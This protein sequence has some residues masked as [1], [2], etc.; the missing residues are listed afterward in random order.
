MKIYLFVGV[1]DISLNIA[2]FSDKQ[3]AILLECV[4][5]LL[6]NWRLMNDKF[7][8]PLCIRPHL[9]T[10]C[11]ILITSTRSRLH[12]LSQK[13]IIKVFR[14]CTI[15]IYRLLQHVDLGPKQLLARV[16]P[17]TYTTFHPQQIGT[18]GKICFD[19]NGASCVKKRFFGRQSKHRTLASTY[20]VL[21]TQSSAIFFGNHRIKEWSGMTFSLILYFP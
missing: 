8:W 18:F 10:N 7:M 11:D 12:T 9:S 5:L 4:L 13:M 21:T 19:T 17:H 15:H 2:G 20:P 3:K 14:K 1:D 16:S 6:T